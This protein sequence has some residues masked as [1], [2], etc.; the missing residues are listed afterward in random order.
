MRQ[1]HCRP[2]LRGVF[3]SETPIYKYARALSSDPSEAW[4]RTL[5]RANSLKMDGPEN[6]C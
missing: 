6:W 2:V 1:L 3:I 5:A 4:A